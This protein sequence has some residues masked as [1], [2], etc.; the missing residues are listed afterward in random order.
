MANENHIYFIIS[1]RWTFS[2]VVSRNLYLRVSFWRSCVYDVHLHEYQLGKT[3][4]LYLST[5]FLEAKLM[6]EHRFCTTKDC[7]TSSID[8]EGEIKQI[9]C[10]SSLSCQ[11]HTRV[12]IQQSIDRFFLTISCFLRSVFL[13]L[14]LTRSS[15]A[16]SKQVSLVNEHGRR[17]LTCVYT[18]KGGDSFNESVVH[19]NSNWLYALLNDSQ[20]KLTS[21]IDVKY[22]NKVL[23]TLDLK[24]HVE[25]KVWPV[26]KTKRLSKSLTKHSSSII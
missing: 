7:H 2:F 8:L 23:L 16:W 17:E 18:C 12:F 10:D 14:L 20:K 26:K 6:M 1:I 13:F 5:M 19:R 3:V 9:Y 25:K 4:E 11:T 15:Y 21:H 22:Q 24:Q